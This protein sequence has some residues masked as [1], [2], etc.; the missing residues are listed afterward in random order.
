[1]I[2]GNVLVAKNRLAAIIDWGGAGYGDAAQDYAPAWALLSGGARATF[3][4]AVAADDAAWIRGRTFELEH[5]VGGILYYKPKR[6]PLGDVME[7]TLQRI[8]TT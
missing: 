6:H 8:L 7:R 1:M 3:R 4:K 5:A 2:P